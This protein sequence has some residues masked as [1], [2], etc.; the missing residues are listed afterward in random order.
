MDNWAWLSSP[1]MFSFISNTLK[2]PNGAHSF[3]ECF[4]L[5]PGR[6]QTIGAFRPTHSECWSEWQ[7]TWFDAVNRITGLRFNEG[8]VS[9]F[10]SHRREDKQE[11]KSFPS[12]KR[13]KQV[14]KARR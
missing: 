4:L 13:D 5:W 6:T 14:N 8:N 9:E 12:A 7:E 3:V 11:G 10:S 2:L 1:C